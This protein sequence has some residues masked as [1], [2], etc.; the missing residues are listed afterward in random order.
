LFEGLAMLER[1]RSFEP[2]SA[3]LLHDLA[4]AEYVAG[5]NDDALRDMK[6][7][8]DLAPNN[9]ELVQRYAGLL[10]ELGRQADAAPFE[11]KAV[12]LRA[13]REKKRLKK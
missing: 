12:E 11:A 2:R 8:M 3:V 13:E 7:A 5:R 6:A 10:K 1:A 9:P 4:A